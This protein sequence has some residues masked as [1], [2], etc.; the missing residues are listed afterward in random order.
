MVR[1]KEPLAE[2]EQTYGN[3]AAAV[4]RAALAFVQS[5]EAVQILRMTALQ[6]EF[7]YV[8]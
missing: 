7:G 3:I 6:I 2:K 8:K 5:V 4:Q 1:L